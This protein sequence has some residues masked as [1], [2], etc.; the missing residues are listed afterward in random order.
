MFS[1]SIA[2]CNQ[3]RL[4]LR[5]NA[6]FSPRLSDLA[7]SGFMVYIRDMAHAVCSLW[8]HTRV[9]TDTSL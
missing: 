3:A 9:L 6:H 7:F 8:S 1:E 4:K 2:G 5:R